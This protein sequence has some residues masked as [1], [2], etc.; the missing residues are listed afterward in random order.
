MQACAYAVHHASERNDQ[1]SNTLNIYGSVQP[2]AEAEALI[3][4][5]F[6]DRA[7]NASGGVLKIVEDDGD[8][9][10]WIPRGPHTRPSDTGSTKPKPK[11][12]VNKPC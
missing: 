12:V 8:E 9:D 2:V 1:V 6:G 10:G 4:D 3:V 7:V 5:T 11:P